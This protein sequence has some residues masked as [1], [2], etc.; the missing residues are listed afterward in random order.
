MSVRVRVRVERVEL[1][2]YCYELRL[3]VYHDVVVTDKTFIFFSHAF[4]SVT[5]STEE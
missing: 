3:R 4:H 5:S 1:K 2:L